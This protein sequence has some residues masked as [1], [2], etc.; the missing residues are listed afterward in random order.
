MKFPTKNKS[1]ELSLRH[2]IYE[3]NRLTK[4]TILYDENSLF[5]L[6]G[7]TREDVTLWVFM[8]TVMLYS[9]AKLNEYKCEEGNNV[10]TF[11]VIPLKSK[12]TVCCAFGEEYCD[13][14]RAINSLM[15]LMRENETD[16]GIFI[17]IK[18]WYLI[19]NNT[20]INEVDFANDVTLQQFK[21]F[22]LWL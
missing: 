11:T 15:E 6:G 2:V 12:S 1:A 8:S 20:I 21:P 7:L 18:K 17:C 22:L 16:V 3:Y 4:N 13:K 9:K 19:K 10:T 5:T 14:D